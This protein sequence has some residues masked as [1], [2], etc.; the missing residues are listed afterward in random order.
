MARNLDSGCLAKGSINWFFHRVAQASKVLFDFHYSQI[1]SV[2]GNVQ[3]YNS[4]CQARVLAV[5]IG[6]RTLLQRLPTPPP[7]FF[8]MSFNFLSY[9]S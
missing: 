8:A 9:G 1:R 6:R 7:K 4:T 3:V 5:V 2:S